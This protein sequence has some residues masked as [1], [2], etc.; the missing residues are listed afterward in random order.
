MAAELQQTTIPPYVNAA[1]IS[2]ENKLYLISGDI[3]YEYAITG[4]TPPNVVYAFLTQFDITQNNAMN[5][6]REML[7]TSDPPGDITAMVFSPINRLYAFSGK[8]IFMYRL[9]HI[10]PM[11]EIP[12]PC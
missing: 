5:P 6:F 12:T 7:G 3:V 1:D 8:N 9:M 2:L 10:D 4:G 11:G